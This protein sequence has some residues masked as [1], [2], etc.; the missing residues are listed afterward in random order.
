MNDLHV[1]ASVKELREIKGWSVRE[2]GRRSGTSASLISRME[3]AEDWNVTLDNLS[4]VADALGI[5]VGDLLNYEA[6]E[7]IKCPICKGRGWYFEGEHPT[8]GG[9]RHA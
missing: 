5:S 1:G 7:R 4:R 2:L 8:V 3:G 6:R 9:G